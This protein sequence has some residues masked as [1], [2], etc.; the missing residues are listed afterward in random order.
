MAIRNFDVGALRGLKRAAATGLGNLV[1]IAGPNG[2]GKSSLLDLLRNQ[3]H[4]IAEPGTEVMFVGPHR[5]WRS[6]QLNR[7]SVYGYAAQS[8]GELL[9]SDAMP[10]FQ[11][12]VPPGL[13]GLQGQGRQSSSADDVQAFVKTSL[14]KLR[15]RQ[16]NLIGAA[17]AEQGGKVIEGSVP[18]LFVPF[19]R[20]VQTLL[21]HLR[22][23]GVVETSPENIQCLFR[24][25]DQPEVTFDIDELSSGEKAQS[26]SC[27][28]WSSVRLES[29]RRLSRLRKGSFL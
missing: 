16:Q 28:H 26:R 27:S 5:T 17:F 9:M 12:V 14:V 20:L 23:Q 19:E 7:V 29:L 10:N 21:P 15:D 8:Y 11:Y 3:R 24:P 18:E 6:S 25:V 22:L 13:Q 2:A 4:Q 1:V